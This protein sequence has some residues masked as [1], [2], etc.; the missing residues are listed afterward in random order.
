MRLPISIGAPV[1]SFLGILPGA[2]GPIAAFISY[3]YSKRLSVDPESFGKG[4]P[5][6]IAARPP[7]QQGRRQRDDA[8]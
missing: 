3:D 2:G 7:S 8:G 5:Q 4:S 1:G 6:G